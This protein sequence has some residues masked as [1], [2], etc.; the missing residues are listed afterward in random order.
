MTVFLSSPDGNL[1]NEISDMNISKR[2]T[3][4]VKMSHQMIQVNEITV[5]L[6]RL[7][8]SSTCK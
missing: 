6:K 5:K 3:R 8:N 2:M 1:D 4:N 7:R